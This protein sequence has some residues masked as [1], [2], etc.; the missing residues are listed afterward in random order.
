MCLRDDTENFVKAKTMRTS[1]VCD[2]V[3]GEA[4][5]LSYTIQWIQELQQQ[6]TNVDFE[7][8]AREL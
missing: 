8:D 3:V 5:G 7:L 1:P 2:T 6:L 4:S